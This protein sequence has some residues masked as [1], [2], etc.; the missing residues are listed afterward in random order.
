VGKKMEVEV[1]E[2]DR[3]EPELDVDEA[4]EGRRS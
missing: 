2:A 1:V 3:G 4:D